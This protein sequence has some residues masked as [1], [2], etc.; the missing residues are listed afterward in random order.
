M[1]FLKTLK[2]CK[3][4]N[5]RRFRAEKSR[6]CLCFCHMEQSTQEGQKI[7]F[8]KTEDKVQLRIQMWKLYIKEWR[9]GI[10][11]KLRKLHF[12]HVWT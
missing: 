4:Q 3:R 8:A 11:R 2:V 9:I 1:N 5:S 6:V 12:E 10:T 7:Y